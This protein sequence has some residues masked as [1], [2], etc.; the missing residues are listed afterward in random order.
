MGFQ[1][2]EEASEWARHRAQGSLGSAPAALWDVMHENQRQSLTVCPTGTL[3]LA[4]Y[5]FV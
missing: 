5:V 2:L 3:Q 4:A 1:L